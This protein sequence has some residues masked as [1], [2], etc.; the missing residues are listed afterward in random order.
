M[1]P[2]RGG[3]VDRDGPAAERSASSSAPV[4][5]AGGA[6]G[7]SGPRLGVVVA[8]LGTPESATPEGVRAFL[9]EF[10]DDP[11]VIGL[12]APARRALL[13]FAILPRRPARIAPNY[14]RF[15]DGARDS[16]PLLSLTRC[17]A[18]LLAERL[19]PEGAPVAVG[20]RHGPPRLSAALESLAARGARGAVVVGLYPQW[21]GATSGSLEDALRGAPMPVEIAPDWSGH[22]LYV[23]A[24]ADSVERALAGRPPPDL[25]LVSFHGIP[26]RV[27]R[28]GDPY[29]AR[30]LETFRLL[31]RE[32]AAR[33]AAPRCVLS[34][35]SRFGPAKWLSPA[36]SDVVRRLPAEGARRIA[37][38]APGFSVD[39][40]ETIE[41]LQE[42]CRDEF[43]EAGGEE[44]IAVPCLNAAR[45]HADLLEAV[46]RGALARLRARIAEGEGAAPRGAARGARGNGR[47]AAR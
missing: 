15:W 25:A 5:G 7:A 27:D 9:A 44:W 2:A 18:A 17:A 39:C 8:N 12:P 6:D 40:I 35:Q 14:A 37:V 3:D 32:L 4:G 33:G 24:L 20:M 38:V 46:A 36:T 19:E 47:G 31:E 45:G 23:A 21:A 1:P 16:S 42:G 22:P 10:L 11:R 30:C 26:E 13:R 28:L 41:E 43:L 34:W 29:R